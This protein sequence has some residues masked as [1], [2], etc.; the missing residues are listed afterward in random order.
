[1]LPITVV[2]FDSLDNDDSVTRSIEVN[3]RSFTI[4]TLNSALTTTSSS[5]SSLSNLV[6]VMSSVLTVL[7]RL[8]AENDADLT[9]LVGTIVTALETFVDMSMLTVNDIEVIS[10]SISQLPSDG[11][12]YTSETLSTL[13][14]IGSSVVTSSL[15]S[16]MY[17]DTGGLFSIVEILVKSSSTSPPASSPTRRRL[18]EGEGLYDIDGVEYFFS[19]ISIV[20]A[21]DMSLGQ[22]SLTYLDSSAYYVFAYPLT[23]QSYQLVVGNY[24]LIDYEDIGYGNRVSGTYYASSLSTYTKLVRTQINDLTLCPVVDYGPIYECVFNVISNF[25]LPQNFDQQVYTY[26]NTMICEKGK[27]EVHPFTCPDGSTVYTNCTGT[28]SMIM[29][30]CVTRYTPQCEI[31]ASNNPSFLVS[32]V[33]DTKEYNDSHVTCECSMRSDRGPVSPLRGVLAVVVNIATNTTHSHMEIDRDMEV[34]VLYAYIG[35]TFGF[36]FALSSSLIFWNNQNMQN[37]GYRVQPLHYSHVENENNL[38]AIENYMDRNYWQPIF[39]GVYSEMKTSRRISYEL[40]R[41][42]GFLKFFHTRSNP[43]P[44]LGSVLEQNTKMF[45]FIFSVLYSINFLYPSNQY[46][47]CRTATNMEEC[48]IGNALRYFSGNISSSLFSLTYMYLFM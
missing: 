25:L 39:Q 37:R 13:I 42:V 8:D 7:P 21:N 24:S 40:F 44:K 46:E 35:I 9:L 29:S 27:E 18:A 11:A 17:E 47:I 23:F 3:E 45:L 33:C 4:N 34:T 30:S 5:T 38:R 41:S 22:S 12:V 15:D 2:V 19:S 26:S 28:E 43:L 6:N 48:E 31:V 36:F 16:M 32:T 14:T 10:T 20:Y 1:M